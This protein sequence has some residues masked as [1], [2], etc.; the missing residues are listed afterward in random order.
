MKERLNY[1]EIIKYMCSYYDITLD[2]MIRLL[3]K[4]EY[5]YMLLLLL[6]NYDCINI[7][8]LK[9]MFELKEGKIIRNNI[10]N[11]EEMLLFNG[12]FREKYF[13]MEHYIQK[14]SVND[15]KTLDINKKM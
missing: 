5:K 9:E 10:R 12:F 7:D 15:K 8:E 6:K 1:N 14:N 13:C 11:A 4:R 2:K 3:K